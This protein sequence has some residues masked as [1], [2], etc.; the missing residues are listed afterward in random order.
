MSVPSLPDVARSIL[1]ALIV[2]LANTG[3]ISQ[4]DAGSFIALLG[5]EDA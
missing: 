3:L 4:V 1:K 2:S 5:L